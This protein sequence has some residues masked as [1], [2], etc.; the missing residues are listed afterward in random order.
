MDTR[1]FHKHLFDQAEILFGDQKIIVLAVSGGAD[2]MALLHGLARVNEL[3][4]CGWQLHVAHLDHGVPHNSSAMCTFAV[5]HAR[6]LALPCHHDHVNVPALSAASGESIEEAGR[7]V[8]YAF[9]EN[10]CRSLSAKRVVTAHHAEDQAETVLFRML[11]G[12]GLRGLRGMRPA[13]PL[14][15]DGDIQLV[16]PMLRLRRADGVAYLQTRHISFMHDDTNDDT[17]AGRRNYVRHLLLPEIETKIN[18]QAVSA[19][20]RLAD[21][22]RGAWDY[23][24]QQIDAGWKQ[25]CAENSDALIC[26]DVSQLSKQHPWI[27]DAIFHQAAMV[28]AHSHKNIDADSIERC[29]RL[30]VDAHPRTVEIGAG[31]TARRSGSFIYVE[32]FDAISRNS[33]SALQN[34][35]HP[36]DTST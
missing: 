27:I 5:E 8:R 19:L 21:Q 1:H 14:T 16:R 17:S 25:T 11:R 32:R 15:E 10:V 23:L 28:V 9:L 13:R 12:T 6:Q 22:Q 33:A 29:R 7:K 2:S 35:P 30:L 24:Q 4:S 36:L 18:P 31:I 26:F 20:T 3:R 34:E